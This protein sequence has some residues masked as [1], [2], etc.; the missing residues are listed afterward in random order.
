MTFAQWVAAATQA[1]AAAGRDADE[2]RRDAAVLARWHLGWSTA[3]W[4]TEVHREVPAEFEA[5]LAP[6]LARRAEAEPIAYLTGEREFYGRTFRVTRDVLIPRPETELVVEEALA[7]LAQPGSGASRP[8]APLVVDIGTGSGCIAVTLALEHPSARIVATDISES[9]LAVAADNA[10]RLGAGD[11]VAFRHGSL[12]AGL[13]EP[14]DAIVSNPPYVAAI[15]R[16]SL[17][18][19]VVGYEPPTAL[20]GGDDGLEVIEALL[21]AAASALVPGGCLVMEIGL[22]QADHAR[23]LIRQARH[24]ELVRLRSDLQMIPRVVVARRSG[25]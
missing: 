23:Q 20:F 10:Q 2:S 4:L 13:D 15:D 8:T 19:D 9:A 11:R 22:G 6:L 21:P 14:I 24:L 3:H 5:A 1:L 18:V 17:P 16:E 12:L 25:G 7:C